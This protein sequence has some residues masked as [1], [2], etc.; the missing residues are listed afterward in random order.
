[1]LKLGEGRVRGKK[2][3]EGRMG[4]YRRREKR[5]EKGREVVGKEV[6]EKEESVADYIE[7]IGREAVR[8]IAA[9]MKEGKAGLKLR[10]AS[11]ILDKVV[12]NAVKVQHGGSI[13][14]VIK[15]SVPRPKKPNTE[16]RR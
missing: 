3:K 2:K 15:H 4:R 12:A 16:E 7:R 1:M 9:T 6:V 8:V 11:K 13:Q 14:F 5:K 10:A